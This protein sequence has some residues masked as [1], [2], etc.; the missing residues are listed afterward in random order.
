MSFTPPCRWHDGKDRRLLL[1]LVLLTAGYLPL[2]LTPAV[3]GMAA[4]APA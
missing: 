2:V 1:L 4:L 3:P